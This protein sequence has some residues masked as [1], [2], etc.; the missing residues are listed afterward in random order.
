MK[1]SVWSKMPTNDNVWLEVGDGLT[2]KEAKESVERKR[3]AAEK[4][5]VEAEFV[6]LP[7]GRQ[8]S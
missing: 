4:H 8:P 6:A 1:Y 7:V 3:A 5:G 2:E